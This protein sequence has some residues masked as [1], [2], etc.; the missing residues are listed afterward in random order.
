MNIRFSNAFDSGTVKRI[1][2]AV[3]NPD[4][5]LRLIISLIGVVLLVAAVW[6]GSKLFFG[7]GAKEHAQPAPPVKVA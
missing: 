4:T 1:P 6:L 7:G 5:R 3:R 2:A